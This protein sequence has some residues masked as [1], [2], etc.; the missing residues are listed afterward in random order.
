VSATTSIYSQGRVC[1]EAQESAQA[2][3]GIALVEQLAISGDLDEL[4][5]V[6]APGFAGWH[7][8]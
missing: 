5:F 4:A 3:D 6:D 1:I 2:Y 7:P 8:S